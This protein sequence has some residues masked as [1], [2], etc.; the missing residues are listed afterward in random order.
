[1]AVLSWWTAEDAGEP[2]ASAAPLPERTGAVRLT[3]V[4]I[5]RSGAP[6]SKC[7]CRS[8]AVRHYFLCFSGAGTP[9]CFSR[10]RST[11]AISFSTAACSSSVHDNTG[12]H[13]LP[14]TSDHS[15]HVDAYC[16]KTFRCNQKYRCELLPAFRRSFS[17]SV[18]AS[19]T[20]KS[21]L[22]LHYRDNYRDGSCC[23]PGRVISGTTATHGLCTGCPDP[24]ESA[25]FLRI[26]PPYSHQQC[27]QDNVLSHPGLH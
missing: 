21:F 27:V 18:H 19:A 12:F 8:E 24:S 11:A 10:S 6:L 3:Q 16:Y 2:P 7:L 22:Q 23:P 25:P 14:V 20:G 4:I 5:Q 13:I 1:M 9:L 17:L 15:N 26:T